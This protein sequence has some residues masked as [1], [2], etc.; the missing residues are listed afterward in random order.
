M[1]QKRV[2]MVSTKKSEREKD[3]A[4]YVVCLGK[5]I[6]LKFAH[7]RSANERQACG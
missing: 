3:K 6:I 7:C 1:K 4:L 2:K 5:E